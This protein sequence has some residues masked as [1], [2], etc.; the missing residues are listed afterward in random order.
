MRRESERERERINVA[1]GIISRKKWKG[2]LKSI[3]T[4]DCN[5]APII[6]FPK[7]FQRSY[8]VMLKLCNVS[9]FL[10]IYIHTNPEFFLILCSN[11][12]LQSTASFASG[13]G[14]TEL[15]PPLFIVGFMFRMDATYINGSCVHLWG[16]QTFFC[17]RL[18]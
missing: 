3:F 16:G 15:K 7:I 2:T 6:K 12:M 17:V 8:S 9:I 1:L 14:T 10:Q 11:N 18:Y 13:T 5:S 4:N